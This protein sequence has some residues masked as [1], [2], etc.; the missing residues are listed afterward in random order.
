MTKKYKVYVDCANCANKMEEAIN[1][2]PEVENCSIAFMT[3]KMSVSFDDS[4]SEEEIKKKIEKT[5]KKVDSDFEI[6]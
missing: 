5:C 3:Q 4:I 2:L 1:K 6:E